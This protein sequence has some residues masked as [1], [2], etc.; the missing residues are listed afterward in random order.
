MAKFQLEKLVRTEAFTYRGGTIQDP[1]TDADVGKA[2]KLSGDNQVDLCADGDEILGFISSV[3]P[4]TLDGYV[5]VGV[6]EQDFQEVDTGSL[7]FGARV[8]AASNPAKG[9]AG[10]TTVKSGT[11]ASFNWIVVRPG[12]IKRT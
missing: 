1:L 8:V 2:V 12:L 6:K 5:I 11:P 3:E 9:T 4:G 10:L 7:T